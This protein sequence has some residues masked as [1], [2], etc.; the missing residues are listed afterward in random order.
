MNHLNIPLNVAKT[1]LT[2]SEN[3][4]TKSMRSERI[5]LAIFCSHSN[6]NINFDFY[7]ERSIVLSILYGHKHSEHKSSFY[8]LWIIRNGRVSEGIKVYVCG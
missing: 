6:N 5:F 8:V 3:M 2:T 7:V 1:S 4:Y